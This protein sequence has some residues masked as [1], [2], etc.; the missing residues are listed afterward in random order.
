MSFYGPEIVPLQIE[1][2]ENVHLFR[3]NHEA[4]DINPLFGFRLECIERMGESDGIWAWTRFNHLPL[5]ALIE[6]KIICMHGGIGSTV[7]KRADQDA[8]L[9]KQTSIDAVIPKDGAV[10]TIVLTD[11]PVK[12]SK[13]LSSST[14]SSEE[15]KKD[16]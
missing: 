11:S 12:A 15:L 5:A 7:F 8:D 4:A 16:D 14:S 10:P 3:G 2:P 1:Y 6:N 13:N 9:T